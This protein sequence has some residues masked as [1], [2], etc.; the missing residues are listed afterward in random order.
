MSLIPRI[1]RNTN[2]ALRNLVQLDRPVVEKSEEEL[3][4]EVEKNYRWN[5]G[6]NSLDVTFFFFGLSLV[7]AYTIVP[8]YISKLTDSTVPVGIAALIAQGSWYLPQLFTANFTER[9]PRMKPIVVNLGL[10]LERLPF[11]V[12][13]ISTFFAIQAPTLALVIFLIGYAWHGF[14]AGMVAPSWQNLIAR[15]FSAERRGRFFGIS[16]ALGTATGMAGAA[17]STWVLSTYDYPRDFTLIFTLAALSIFVSLFFLALTR[18]PVPSQ[19]LVERTQREFFHGVSDIIQKK[20][21][22]R[23]FLIARFLLVF[24][25]MGAAFVT[26]AA[27]R[28]WDV[29]DGTVGVF[30]AF[31]LLGQGIGTLGLGM[32]ADKKGHKVSIEISAL[33]A[34]LAFFFA[35]IAPNPT[36]YFIT[37]FLLGIGNGGIM[38]SGILIVLEFAEPERRPTYIG[39]AGTGVGVISMIAPLVGVAIAN[40]SFT[41]LFGISAAINLL[42]LVGLVFTVREPRT[43]AV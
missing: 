12:L 3:N 37:F 10:F 36:F 8:L 14:G 11:W 6:V 30:T 29:S 21:N 17:L 9:S 43:Q 34:V 23:R 20:L 41:L 1:Q 26:V 7:S 25:S 18:E 40:V 35:F 42:A 24:G 4:A 33:A 28:V 15:C 16:M 2:Q 27:L 5:F 13:V 32:M 19:K 38:V 22:F 39:I 31:Q